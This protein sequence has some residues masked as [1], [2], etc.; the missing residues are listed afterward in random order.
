MKAEEIRELS[1][2]DIQEKLDNEEAALSKLKLEHAVSDLEDPHDMRRRKRTIARLKT[3]LR[4]REL[5]QK[6]G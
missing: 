2:V 1:E 4:E 3:V 6:K 5:E